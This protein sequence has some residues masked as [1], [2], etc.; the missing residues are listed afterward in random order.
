M[1]KWIILL[2]DGMSDE[3]CEALNGKTPLE[4]AVT[5]HLDWFAQNGNVGRMNTV[6]ETLPPGSDVANMGILGFDPQHFYTGR[7]PIEAAAMGIRV[8]NNAVIF[9]CNFVTIDDNTMTDFTSGHID[10]DDSHALIDELNDR[11]QS[12]T[13]CFY[14]GVGYRHIVSLSEQFNQL[15]TTPPHDIIGQPVTPFLPKGPHEAQLHQFMYKCHQVLKNSD[16][17][18]R[19]IRNGKRPAT[20][21][22]TWSQG[23]YP[24][25]PSF[26]ERFGLSGGIVTAV[27]LLKGLAR[28]TGLVAPNIQG[29]TGFVDTNYK[30][31]MNAAFQ[32]LDNHDYCYVHIEAPDECGHMGDAIL[33]TKAIEDFDRE[34]CGPI[35]AYCS[36][37]KDTIVCILPDHPTPCR[38]KT[39]S[40]DSVPFITYSP[41]Q[42]ASHSAKRYTEQCA[43]ETGLF[44]PAVWDFVSGLIKQSSILPR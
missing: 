12:D 10:N 38:L 11:F 25:L 18:R 32:I 3:A 35:K 37:N 4:A 31:K 44:Y 33:K 39:H 34:V 43:T 40:R 24:S 13:V 21:I 16:I 7:G 1:T 14:P 28:L 17:N 42:S 8:P 15:E 36:Q 19:R 9:R 23:R 30:N 41:R 27:D 22:W 5:P 20:H 29:A 6:P 2:G 26:H